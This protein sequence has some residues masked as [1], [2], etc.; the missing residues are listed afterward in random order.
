MDFGHARLRFVINQPYNTHN[1]TNGVRS[2]KPAEK[3]EGADAAADD[4]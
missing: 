4:S 2:D 3:E 1:L